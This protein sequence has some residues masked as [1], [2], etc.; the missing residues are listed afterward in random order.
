MPGR[1]FA[2]VLFDIGGVLYLPDLSLNVKGAR[3]VGMH[4]LC[5]SGSG[6]VGQE[7]ERLLG[8]AGEMPR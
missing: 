7:I 4:A 5:Y 8:L 6:A 1:V 3:R 2:A